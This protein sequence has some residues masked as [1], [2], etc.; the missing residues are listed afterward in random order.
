MTKINLFT[1]IISD[2]LYEN[3]ETPF[4]LFR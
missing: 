1:H 2:A 4:M 3:I